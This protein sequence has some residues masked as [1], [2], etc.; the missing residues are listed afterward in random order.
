VVTGA[1][2]AR[3]ATL[4][5]QPEISLKQNDSYTFF[6]VLDDVLKPGPTGTNV[7]DMTLLFTF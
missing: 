6:S 1:T 7:N 5:M 2:F 3:A 4:G